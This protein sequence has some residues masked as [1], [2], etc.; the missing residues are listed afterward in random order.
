MF[1]FFETIKIVDGILQ[2]PEYHQ[3]RMNETMM[4]FYSEPAHVFVDKIQIPE[5]FK[6]GLVKCR[7]SY[8]LS[9]FNTD[10][11]YYNIKPVKTL[12]I[13]ECDN[14]DYSYKYTDRSLFDELLKR[15]N[16]CDDILIVK[17]GKITDTGFSNVV[18]FDGKSFITP[19]EPL[20]NGTCR[21]RMLDQGRIE[22]KPVFLKD[23]TDFQYLVIINAM[24]GDDFENPVLIAD[25]K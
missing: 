5:M 2:Y 14:A 15:R 23:L 4:N 16:N 1:R 13:I 19:D 25:I 3:K 6:T 10:F 20:L 21:R 11:S 7:L 9:G 12:K 24:R 22:A 8:D 17:N 18:L